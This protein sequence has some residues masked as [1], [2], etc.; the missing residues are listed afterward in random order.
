MLCP[1]PTVNELKCEEYTHVRTYTFGLFF[2]YVDIHVN[3]PHIVA[4][5]SL[6]GVK[7]W[8]FKSALTK[9]RTYMYMPVIQTCLQKA[10]T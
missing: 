8:L 6:L 3:G 4:V 1:R 5:V 10:M 2:P 9:T 7:Y